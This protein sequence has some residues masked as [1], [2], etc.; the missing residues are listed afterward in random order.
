VFCCTLLVVSQV[1]E[2]W[3][4]NLPFLRTESDI[5]LTTHLVLHYECGRLSWYSGI[6][7]ERTLL[8]HAVAY[9]LPGVRNEWFLQL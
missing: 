5:L 2:N 4:E 9:V 8:L 1:L 6:A 3:I 7:L